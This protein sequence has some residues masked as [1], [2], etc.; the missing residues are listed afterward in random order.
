MLSE[1]CIACIKIVTANVI[2]ATSYRTSVIPHVILE[3]RMHRAALATFAL[4][5]ALGLVVPLPTMAQTGAPEVRIAQVDTSAYPQVTL[6]V[7]VSGPSGRPQPGLFQKDFQITEDGSPVT[8]SGFVGGG[9]TAVRALLVMDCSGSMSYDDKIDAARAAAQA[10]VAQMRPGDQTGLLSFCKGTHLTQPLSEDKEVLGHAIRRLDA[11]GPTP[12]YDGLIAGVRSLDGQSGRRALLLLS[13]GRDCY[14]PPCSANPGSTATLEEALRQAKASGLSAEV[15]GLGDRS[16]SDDSNMGIDEGVLRRIADETGGEYFYA[17]D[18]A[19]L[20]ALYA[21]LGG[22]LQQ[23]Y[24]MTYVSPRPFFDGTRRDIQ[25]RVGEAMSAGG[26]TEQH[27]LNVQS[28]PLVGVL[29]LLPLLGLL[30]VPALFGRR[31]KRLPAIPEGVP[32][33]ANAVAAPSEPQTG[34]T[35]IT[36]A[37][38]QCVHCRAELRIGARF[39]NSCG[40]AQSATVAAPRREFCDQCGRP[41]LEGAHFCMECGAEVPAARRALGAIHE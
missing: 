10:F 33:A 5:I 39:C 12:L 7:S 20:A 27:L 19:A 29:L 23:E 9:A 25:V 13:D 41:M 26:Y 22:S 8:I 21:R 24:T 4:L 37:S 6:H 2:R 18:G 34:A 35:T 38:A 3:D 15:I 11:D 28:S 16:D 40:G 14:K 1:Y 30:A 36:A 31:N 32:E 17:P